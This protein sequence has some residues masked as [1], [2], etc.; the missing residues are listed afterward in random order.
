MNTEQAPTIRRLEKGHVEAVGAL[1]T[2]AQ[3]DPRVVYDGVPW[4][5]GGVREY[6][7]G[8][9]G[10]VAINQSGSV[11][12][13]ALFHAP[14]DQEHL[15]VVKLVAPTRAAYNALYTSLI[16]VAAQQGKSRPNMPLVIEIA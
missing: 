15:E 9:R 2:A 4:T 1:E 8:G 11:V 10:L 6:L 7:R 3:Y 5:T 13:F 14:L 12:G 16:A